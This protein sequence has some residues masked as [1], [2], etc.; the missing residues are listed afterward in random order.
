VDR[1]PFDSATW[2]VILTDHARERAVSRLSW[3][4]SREAGTRICADV[5]DAVREGRRAKTLPR[6]FAW[7]DRKKISTPGSRF[8]WTEGM[9]RIYVV[10]PVRGSRGSP[11][12]LVL[13]VLV[14]Q[15][16]VTFSQLSEEVA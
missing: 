16:G 8:V 9:E 10:R 14:R 2:A 12:W 4:S 13:T 1:Q 5:R 6:E 11:A 7:K 3:V 15:R